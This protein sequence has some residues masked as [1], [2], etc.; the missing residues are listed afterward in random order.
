MTL[1][2]QRFGL[3]FLFLGAVVLAL[4]SV[5]PAQSAGT[6]AIAG[7]I[8]DP[9]GAVIQGATV[10]ATDIRTGE[11]RTA[12]STS[13]GAYVV[14]LLRPGTYRVVISKPG[15]KNTERPAVEVHITETI[16]DNVQMVLG[17]QNQTVTVNDAGELLQ[18][19]ESTLGN[20]V[21]QREVET[22]PLVTRN[23]Q[24]IL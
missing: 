2:V 20:V 15:F 11:S 22:L 9:A 6:G 12:T 14:P 7:T 21:D 13:T 24:Q 5:M 10:T 18:T 1:F 17:A 19:Q 23:Y 3:R 8:T 16:T 4:T